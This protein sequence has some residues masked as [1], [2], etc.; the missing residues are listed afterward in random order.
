MMVNFVFKSDKKASVIP[1]ELLEASAASG[2][3]TVILSRNQ[4]TALPP[5]YDVLVIYLNV[6]QGKLVSA[7]FFLAY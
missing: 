1:D 2:V 4:L 3:T 7:I 5:R 6:E